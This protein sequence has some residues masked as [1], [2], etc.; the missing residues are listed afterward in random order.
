M[1]KSFLQKLRQQPKHIRDQVALSVAGVVTAG[2]FLVWIVTIP[3]QLASRIETVDES[4]NTFSSFIDDV[5]ER[6]TSFVPETEEPED[7]LTGVATTTATSNA[8]S[9]APFVATTT[10]SWQ[11]PTSTAS[12]TRTGA[13]SR[14]P[15]SAT[16]TPTTSQITP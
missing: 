16:T 9:A 14:A 11:R 13:S 15:Y 10:W 4:A 6:S 7:E 3:S 12:T 1:I 2:V 5:T 8:T